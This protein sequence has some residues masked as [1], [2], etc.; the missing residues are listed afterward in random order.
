MKERLAIQLYTLREESAEDFVGVLEKVAELG[1]KGVEFA[2]FYNLDAETLKGH[3]D[4]LGL[5]AVA[6]HTMPDLLKDSIDEVITYNK[7]IGNENIVCPW[8]KW[9]SQAEFDDVVA[10]LTEAGKKLKSAG[11]NFY[12]HNHDHEF[13]EMDGKYGLD[14]L[15]EACASVDMMMELDTCWATAADVNAADYMEANKEICRLIHLKDLGEKDGKPYPKA[16]GEG[17]API[18]EILDKAKALDIPWVIIEND[19][20]TPTGAEDITRSMDY[21]KGVL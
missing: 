5:Q 7:I 12:Y 14:Q 21:L 13:I 3:L 20:P 16:I 4:R 10:M 19:F 9:E 15:F 18:A 6:S 2:G 11:L 1:F 8:S 17:R